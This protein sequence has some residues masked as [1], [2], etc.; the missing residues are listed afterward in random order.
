MRTIG[1]GNLIGISTYRQFAEI[2]KVIQFLDI[3]HGCSWV[4]IF[5]GYHLMIAVINA[6]GNGCDIG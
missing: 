5:S 3:K 6:N 2:H 4:S 1:N